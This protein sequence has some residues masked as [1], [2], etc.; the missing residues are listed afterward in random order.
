MRLRCSEK[1]RDLVVGKNWRDSVNEVTR[2]EPVARKYSEQSGAVNKAP[3]IK[4][5][6]QQAVEYSVSP[7]LATRLAKTGISVAFSSYQSGL[8]YFLGRNPKGGINIHQSA[9]PKPMGL[10]LDNNGGLTLTGGFQI[11]RFENVLERDQ[12]INHVFDACYVPRV[13]HVTGGLDAHDV[14]V[15]SGGRPIFINTRFNCIA[16]VSARHSFEV[17]WKPPFISE[18]IDED[19]CH[20]NGLAMEDQ[21]PRYVTAVSRSNTIDGWRD[22][23]ADGGV[24]IDV[25]SNEIVCEGLSMPHSPRIHNGELWILNS[26]TG[27][28]GVVQI[29]KKGAGKFEPRVFC[30]GFLRGLAFHEGF[31]FVGLS[32][33][34]YKRF[35]GLALDQRLNDADSDPWCGIQ[36]IDLTSGT[37]VDWLRIDGNISELYDLEIIPGVACAMAVA[38]QSPEAASLITFDRQYPEK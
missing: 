35:E 19:R 22:R 33:P 14:G 29:D 13:V 20:L 37:C 12:Q 32:K 1:W 2:A 24:V 17:I 23:R 18:I 27:E 6:A 8:L 38:P 10:S 9:M 4:A 3:E 31:A 26:G 34:R 16:T 28:L 30:P 7:G 21:K 11:M 5:P 25:Q 36:V 15:D